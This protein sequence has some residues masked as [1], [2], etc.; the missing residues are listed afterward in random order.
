MVFVY[1]KLLQNN[2]MSRLLRKDVTSVPAF[3]PVHLY[4][5]KKL[6][7]AFERLKKKQTKRRITFGSLYILN[8]YDLEV[9]SLYYG[10]EWFNLSNMEVTTISFDSMSSFLCQ[11]WQVKDCTNAYVFL[12][13]KANEEI[14]KV[15]SDRRKRQ[16]NFIREFLS[17]YQFGK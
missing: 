2:E 7:I 15:F 8:R 3:S 17:E 14:N 9:L 4:K 13:N 10:E 1:D 16:G 5:H 11:K 6:Y 12:G